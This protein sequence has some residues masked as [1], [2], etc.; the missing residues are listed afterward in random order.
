MSPHVQADA[1]AFLIACTGID[2]AWVNKVNISVTI[3]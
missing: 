3:S 2:E 1:L